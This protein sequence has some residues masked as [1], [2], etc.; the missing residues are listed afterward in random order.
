MYIIGVI[1]EENDTM[2]LSK[3]QSK[4]ALYKKALAAL[5]A[6]TMGM[7]IAGCSNSNEGTQPDTKE[8]TTEVNEDPKEEE[9]KLPS[10]TMSVEE[11]QSLAAG[12][13][14]YLEDLDKMPNEA[15]LEEMNLTTTYLANVIVCDPE[16]TPL[17]EGTMTPLGVLPENIDEN[18]VSE[19]RFDDGYISRSELLGI[20]ILPIEYFATEDGQA[21]KYFRDGDFVFKG[22]P[23]VSD[24]ILDQMTGTQKVK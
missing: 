1:R 24:K 3:I 2:A 9:F 21:I 5:L 11:T 4:K 10:E 17:E 23:V 13:V 12:T 19:E 7:G 15:T 20:K 14:I 8:Q 16:G 18:G 22:G 6:G